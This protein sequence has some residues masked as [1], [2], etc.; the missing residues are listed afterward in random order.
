MSVDLAN[1]A[2]RSVSRESIQIKA[3]DDD[4]ATIISWQ[5]L[6]AAATQADVDLA[7]IYAQIRASARNLL[8]AQERAAVDA[9][10]EH[11]AAQS[12]DRGFRHAVSVDENPAAHGGITTV[13]TCRCGAQRLHNS[14]NG[15]V[16]SGDWH[17][18][19]VP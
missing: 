8:I 17:Y 5:D 13:E 16:E 2:I 15:R 4:H 10:S 3:S 12:F 6:D 7:A 18:R 9:C 1:L 14:N 11:R 19:E